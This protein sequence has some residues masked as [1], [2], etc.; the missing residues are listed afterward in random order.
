M[1]T[2]HDYKAQVQISARVVSPSTAEVLTVSLGSGEVIKKGVKVDMRD[3]SQ[4][5]GMMN[6]NVNHPIMN[7]AID[8][9]LAKLAPQLEQSF[10]KLPAIAVQV[11]GLVADAQES[12]R[13]VI[14]IGSKHGVKT[15][16]RL[17]V[18]REGK[19]IRDPATGKVLTRDDTLLGDAVVNSVNEAFSMA[20]FEG[21]GKVQTGD[22]VRSAPK[23][24]PKAN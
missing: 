12:G 2:K 21:A 13:L 18:W 16:D 19:E 4:A 1:S 17:Q 15:G 3:Q 7:E 11:S 24:A 6:G 22:A 8:Q 14:N 5:M 23:N 9:A 20:T 10:V